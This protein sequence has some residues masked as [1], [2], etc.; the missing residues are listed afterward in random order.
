MHSARYD[1]R[2]KVF[3]HVLN[4]NVI[5]DRKFRREGVRDY[6]VMNRIARDE[7]LI[8]RSYCVFDG[9][10]FLDLSATKKTYL[11]LNQS[12]VALL[13]LGSA[14]I[15]LHPTIT[16]TQRTYPDPVI[17]A[18]ENATKQFV[19]RFVSVIFIET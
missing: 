2:K 11:R 13:N 6:D 14:A 9:L 4:R 16:L 7:E 19:L 17:V 8:L 18:F 1:R 12:I 5:P 3:Y 10:I 15:S